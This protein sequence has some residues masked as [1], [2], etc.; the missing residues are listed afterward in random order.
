MDATGLAVFVQAALAGGLAAGAR[1]LRIS[2]LTAS[3][4]L[5][6][7]ES[8][9]GVRL[10]HRT[11][12]SLSLTAEGETFLPHAQA[13]L[14]AEA[15]ARESVR[16]SGRGVSGLLRVTTSAAF[17]R[18]ALTPIVAGFLRA[19][20]EVQ[21]DLLMT[22][23]Q[24]DLVTEGLDLAIRIANLRDSSLVG[25][26]VADNLRDLYASPDYLAANGVPARLADLDRHQCLNLTGE[27]HWSF[28]SGKTPVRQA[29]RARFTANS[30]E[31]LH[32][33][34]LEGLGV[35]LFS[36]WVTDADVAAGR[37][38]RLDLTDARPEPLAVW[39]LYPSRRLAPPKVSAF[40]AAVKQGLKTAPSSPVSPGL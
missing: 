4:R 32:A 23:H 40:I 18:R 7:L 1:R 19:N 30:V 28:L 13:L 34:C 35:G 14:E 6:A 33:A 17:G 22:D 12:R 15:L 31:G 5:S 8:E 25:S 27:G 38:I 20:P 3:R 2:P 24:I 21:V 11:T 36:R 29:V 16:P 39:A 9:L 10:L 37:L 26:R